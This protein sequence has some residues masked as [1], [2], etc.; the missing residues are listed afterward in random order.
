M[1]LAGL[2]FHVYYMPHYDVE[3][4][5][6]EGGGGLSFFFLEEHGL[7]F[8]FLPQNVYIFSSFLS[9]IYYIKRDGFH[10][11]YMLVLYVLFY[12]KDNS[13][14]CISYRASFSS[15]QSNK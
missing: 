10:V 8:F 11:H 3:F 12:T 2:C 6:R 9:E 4:R 15:S 5:G 14:V 1:R 13:S 7:L